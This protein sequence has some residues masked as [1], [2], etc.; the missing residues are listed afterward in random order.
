MSKPILKQISLLL[1]DVRKCDRGAIAIVF[2]VSVSVLM[3]SIGA[4]IDYA[5][6]TSSRATLQ[7]AADAASLAAAHEVSLAD[8]KSDNLAQVAQAV[9]EK[10]IANQK[11]PFDELSDTKVTS[12]VRMDPKEVEVNIRHNF[13]AAFGNVFSF[14]DQTI[15]VQSIAQLVGTPNICVLALEAN[16]PG[17]IQVQLLSKMQGNNCAVF[18][19]STSTSGISVQ[20][21]AQLS[22]GRIC[23]A[24]GAVGQGSM[25]PDPHLD[26]PQFDDPLS[27]RIEP[28]IDGCD[29]NNR[30]ILGQQVTLDP[31]VFCGGLQ[32]LGLADVTLEPGVY[33][34]SG[35]LFTVEGLARLSGNGVTIFLDEG[36]TLLFG[37]TSTISLSASTAGPLAG[38]LIFASREQSVLNSHTI[39]SRGAQR[40]VGTIYM[41]RNTLIVDGSANVGSESAYTAIVARRVLLLN[42]PNVVLNANYGDTNVPVPTGIRTAGQPARLVK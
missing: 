13:S 5:R 40:L 23:S 17:A 38:L 31:G 27:G 34:I 12:T 20:P 39:L 35:G 7:A 4:S 32:I 8:H 16:E 22:A 10:Y 28:S 9:A 6:Y 37:P 18:S 29:Y 15:E 26:C 33:I 19:N 36:A 30:I 25:S 2:A 3:L 14:G 24:G 41:P 21:T 11:Q 42:S 1:S